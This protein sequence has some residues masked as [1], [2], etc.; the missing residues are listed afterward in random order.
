VYPP[1]KKPGLPVYAI[2]QKVLLF[3]P[4]ALGARKQGME[5]FW[6]G[7]LFAIPL[8]RNCKRPF[9]RRSGDRGVAPSSHIS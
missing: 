1:K 7:T 6:V 5:G 9:L 3:F 4:S 2:V 8:I